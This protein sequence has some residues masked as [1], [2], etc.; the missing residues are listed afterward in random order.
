M[1]HPPPTF[2]FS[3]FPRTFYHFFEAYLSPSK[4]SLAGQCR[5]AARYQSW[6]SFGTQGAQWAVAVVPS[7]LQRHAAGVVWSGEGW[8]GK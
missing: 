3:I 4:P 8:L 2:I 5:C 7:K 1:Y 6:R